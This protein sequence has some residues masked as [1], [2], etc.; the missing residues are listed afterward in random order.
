[1]VGEM[2]AAPISNAPTEVDCRRELAADPL[3]PDWHGYLGLAL[4]RRRDTAAAMAS[5]RTAVA[6]APSDTRHLGNLGAAQMLCG[7]LD[8]ARQ[9]LARALAHRPE[10]TDVRSN[11][12]MLSTAVGGPP[13][14]GLLK[15][16]LVRQPDDARM[17]YHL[18]TSADEQMETLI[19]VG[20]A[21]AVSPLFA[22]A[23]LALA[24][25]TEEWNHELAET[26]RRRVVALA[27][28]LADVHYNQGLA[29]DRSRDPEISLRCYR[30][31][32]ALRQE[33]VLAE[34]NAALAALMVG[35]YESGFG[36]FDRRW[37]LSNAPVRPDVAPEWRGEPL[38]G[39]AL[40][41]YAEQGLGDA[42]QFA[43]FLPRLD[44]LAANV[45]VAVPP[46]LVDLMK[47]V[48]FRGRV[49]DI[50]GPRLP[51]NRQV[52]LLGLP[53]LLGVV[54]AAGIAVGPYMQA[55]TKR[56]EAWRARLRP[57][58]RPL[59]G[60][61]WRGNANFPDERRRSPGLAVLKPLLETPDLRFVSLVKDPAGD[62]LAGTPILD[63]SDELV[64]MAETAAL[65]AAL[66]LVITSD[67]SVAHLAGALG[68]PGWVMLSSTAD[69]RWGKDGDRT[70]WYP[71]LHLFR[72]REPGD[73]TSVV[74]DIG[75]RL[76]FGDSQRNEWPEGLNLGTSGA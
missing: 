24:S 36:G 45:T 8:T 47:T 26:E 76:S 16:V 52:A 27:P 39:G 31:A 50:T 55:H 65:T 60:L 21:L 37:Q 9:S 4:L 70:I 68:R 13:N 19:F 29:S 34:W 74:H 7:N 61:C 53:R 15:Q 23:R 20:R 57:N 71:T 2:R 32:A 62:D 22:E 56:I 14:R 51:A 75:V 44:E 42:I 12:A 10:D 41:V 67:T 66:D 54:G 17:L 33:H 3:A 59:I 43:R 69:W 49:A 46:A 73:W 5:L 25:T 64:S 11:L 6:L 30:R 72:Q 35:N 48:R 18:G 58:G 38:G 40:H 63:V 1:M 28:D